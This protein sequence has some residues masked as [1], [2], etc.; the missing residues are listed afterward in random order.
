MVL[1]TL[2]VGYAVNVAKRFKSEIGLAR[3]KTWRFFHLAE[4]R[5]N[6]YDTQLS[7]NVGYARHAISI[8][9]TRNSFKR[10]G[11][12]TPKVWRDTGKN[13]KGEPNPQWFEQIWFAGNHSDVGG[14][15]VEN[16]S[17]L[18]DISLHWM[19]E[20]ACTVGMHYD[21]NQL[22]LYPDPSGPQHDET[23]S[24]RVFKWIGGQP[25]PVR[26]DAPLHP[27]VIARFKAGDVLHYD[28]MQNYR[29]TNLNGHQA[30]VGFY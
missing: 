7:K 19:L 12:G 6:F 4:P 5:M 26:P 25:R 27:S 29:P 8:D 16:E 21:K 28:V 14:S 30:T 18:S 11:W 1:T 20:A 15:Y 9:E 2:A 22:R 3:E 10:V 17:R 13:E 23:K 24:S